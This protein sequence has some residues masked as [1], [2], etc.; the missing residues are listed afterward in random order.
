MNLESKEVVVVM[1]Y[2]YNVE[3]YVL[4]KYFGLDWYI[5]VWLLRIMKNYKLLFLILLRLYSYV[6]VV[7]WFLLNNKCCKIILMCLCCFNCL[8]IYI[9]IDFI[10]LIFCVCVYLWR[11]WDFRLSFFIVILDFNLIV[12][13]RIIWY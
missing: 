11:W 10:L 5:F 12:G 2:L 13:M 7:F 8:L 1:D 3:E 4:V 9:L 6:M